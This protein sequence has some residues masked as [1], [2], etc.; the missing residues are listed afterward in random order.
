MVKKII[1]GI[2]VM[3]YAGTVWAA[4]EKPADEKPS[5]TGEKMSSAQQQ[6]MMQQTMQAMTPFFGQVM[7][8]MMEAQLE[9]LA[10]PGTAEKLAT[11]TRN[12]YEALVRKGF[13]KEEALRIAMTVGFP[14]FPGMQK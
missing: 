14:A 10:Q 6:E 3:M 8:A 4:D 1:V 2:A 13:S 7:K 12:Y 5:A 11:Y 9:I